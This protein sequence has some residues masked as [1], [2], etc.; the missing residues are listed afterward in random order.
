[1]LSY[2]IGG[3]HAAVGIVDSESLAISFLNSCAIDSNGTAESILNEL[4]VLGTTALSGLSGPG[5]IP[6]G[7]AIA[8]PGPFIYE[9]GI[10][11][12][13]HKFASLYKMDLRHELAERFGISENTVGF[14]NDAQAFLLGENYAGGTRA[15]SRSVGLTLGTGVGSAFAICGRLVE[16]GAGVPHGGEIY[17]L[18]WNEQTV[19]DE[20]STRAIQNLFTKMTGEK[21]SV[22][23]ICLAAQQDLVAKM[24]LNQ[25][26]RTLGM[27]IEKYCMPFQPD[28]IVIGGGISRSAHL[29]LPAVKKSVG[30]RTHQ[31]LTIS[32][33]SSEAPLIGG[34]I[35]C[36]EMILGAQWSRKFRSWEVPQ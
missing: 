5:Q 27:V 9:R 10:S 31:L 24:V 19:E 3:S 18:P 35:R 26:G 8:V 32:E 13:R 20:I 34:A 6:G 16:D 17:C 14:V 12:L 33:L 21:K 36:L 28:K 4:F 15:A 22:R 23:D 1:V 2:D 25:F 11:L 30:D 29:F 7:I